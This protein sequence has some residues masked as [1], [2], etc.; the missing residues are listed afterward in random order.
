MLVRS[1]ES[2]DEDGWELLRQ[3]AAEHG[4]VLWVE[5]VGIGND[6]AITFVDGSVVS[7]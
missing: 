1:G 7:A 6:D 3:F 2:L 5:R 4:L